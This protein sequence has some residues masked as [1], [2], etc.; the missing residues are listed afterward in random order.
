M[1]GYIAVILIFL[2]PAWGIGFAMQLWARHSAQPLLARNLSLGGR[3]LPIWLSLT[4]M[5]SLAV[6]H[7]CGGDILY[8]YHSCTGLPDAATGPIT[9]VT[10]FSF[11]FAAAWAGLTA[12]IGGAVEY[13]ARN[14]AA[15]DTRN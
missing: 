7:L 4:M 11:L 8:G 13:I 10:V 6:D 5:A 9:A 3:Y 2:V 1:S 12:L 15:R 14:R